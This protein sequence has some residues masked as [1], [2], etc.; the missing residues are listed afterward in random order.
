M[1]HQSDTCNLVFSYFRITGWSFVTSCG[2]FSGPFHETYILP[3]PQE[4]DHQIQVIPFWTAFNA[5]LSDKK[6]CQTITAYAPI[7]DTKPADMAIVYTTMTKSKEMASAL[8]QQHMV[9]TMDQQLYAV[10]QQVKWSEQETFQ[11]TVLRLGGFHTLCAYI[12]A[13]GKLWGDG[14][15]LSMLTDSGVYAGGTATQ[16]VMGKQF[17]RAVRGLTLVFEAVMQQFIVQ[18]MEWCRHHADDHTSRTLLAG[19]CRFA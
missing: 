12:S 1:S 6:E 4:A 3:M 2:C 11:N 10:A 13:I 19:A 16:M 5:Q 8:G 9:H 7:I 15:L 17:N 18:F 14:G